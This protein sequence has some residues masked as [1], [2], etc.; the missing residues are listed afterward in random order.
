M[1]KIGGTVLYLVLSWLPVL[2]QSAQ[3]LLIP[4]V[5]DGGGWQTTFVLTNRTSNPASASLSFRI[6]TTAGATQVW[7]PPFLEVSST[8]GLSVAGGSTMYL[9]TPGA[10]ASL[11]Q[12]WAIVNADAGI[13]AYAIFTLRNPGRQDQDG[14]AIAAPSAT[15]ILVP[16]D[17]STGLVTSVGVVNPTGISQSISVNITTSNGTVGHGA[18]PSI[19]SNGHLAFLL[20]Q[21]FPT[22]VGQR[23]LAEFY[24]TSGSFSLIALRAN[25]TGAFTAAPAYF[26][27]GP[28]IISSGTPHRL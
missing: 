20:P 6:D 8:T 17:N 3:T 18:L 27:S 10:A 9:H 21:Q 25:P 13:V 28:P 16:F 22:I 14:T 5:V 24:S 11:S 12:G 26:E 7:S 19:P 4:Q 2:V 15:R 23:G 1:T